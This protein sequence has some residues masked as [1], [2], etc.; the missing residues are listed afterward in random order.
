MKAEVRVAFQAHVTMQLDREELTAL[1][2]VLTTHSVGANSER[3][4]DI[5]QDMTDKVSG[6]LNEWDELEEVRKKQ[7]RYLIEQEGAS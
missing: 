3:E 7:I 5:L 2:E 1:Y 4:G 6:L